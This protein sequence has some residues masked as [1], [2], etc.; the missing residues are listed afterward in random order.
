MNR[1]IVVAPPRCPPSLA[2]A[3]C[4][5]GALGIFDGRFAPEAEL[6]DGLAQI[7][8]YT[9]APYGLRLPLSIP[10]FDLT[11]LLQNVAR[12]PAALIVDVQ[13]QRVDQ[14]AV[15]GWRD[16]GFTVLAVVRSEAEAVV[17]QR[18]GVDG[19]LA[20]G[21]E[22][23][24]WVGQETTF[25]LLQRLLRHSHLP[26]W[27]WGGIGLHTAAAC[28]VAGAA[29]VVLDAQLALTR[30]STLPTAVKAAIRRMDGSETALLGAELNRPFRLY[31]RP[32][33]SLVEQL[34][35]RAFALLAEQKAEQWASEVEQKIGWGALTEAVWPLGQDAAFA[36]S[37]ADNY[38]TVGGV[39]A[40]L[41]ESIESHL[42][43]ARQLQPL[44]AQS[45]LAQAHR[46][47]Y[48]IVQ[49]PMTRVS[50]SVTFCSDVEAGGG[51]PFLAL[52]LLRAPQVEQLLAETQALMGERSWGVGILGFVPLDLR[53][54]QLA[55][56]LKYR[57]PFA[58]I[59]GGR[60]DQAQR[61]QEAGI[62]TYLHVPS[63]G[64]L[65]LFLKDGARHFIFEGRECG[66][67]VGPR[68]SFVLWESMIQ[69]LLEELPADASDCHLLFAGGIH[70]RLSAAMVAAMAAPLAARGVKVGVLMG[71]AYLFTEEAVSSG[72]IQLGFQEAA[73]HCDETVLL[74]SGPGHATRCAP[75]PF[76]D[77]FEQEKI[78]LYQAGHH[79]EQ[80]RQT[81]E[82]LN[83]GR[84]RIA[85]KGITRHPD[86]GATPDVPKYVTLSPEQQ[87]AD[88]MYM[89]GQVAAL[90]QATFTV[91][92]L[93]EEVSIEGSKLLQRLNR[94]E[95]VDDQPAKPSRVA[96]I[97]MSNFLPKAPDLESFW[98]NIR[99]GVYAI[100]E[101]PKTR[102]DWQL[103]FDE[104]PQARDKIYSRWGGFLEDVPFDPLAWGIP[105]ASLASI[106]PMHL[107]SLVAT[108]NALQDAGYAKRPFDRQHTS[109]ILGA[110]GGV[111]DLGAQYILRSGLPLLFGEAG[112]EL[113]TAAGNRLPQWTEDSFA[114]LLL[115]VAAGRIANRFDFGGVNYI[116]DAACASSL[117]ALYLAV[118]ELESGSSNVVIAGGV[119]TVQSPFGY[120]CFSK[121][122]ALSPDGRPRTFDAE[123]N[124]IAISEGVVMLV[125]KRLEDAE[126]DGDRIYA[127]IQGV[128]GSSDGRALS[129]TAPRAEGQRV[130]L[131][132]AYQ[133]AGFPITSVGLFEAH[134]TGTAVGDRTEALALGSFLAE[135][136]A[137]TAQHA[138]GSVKS[139]VGHTKASAGVAGVVKMALALYHQ[140]LPPTLG[141]TTPNPKANFKAG[142][143]YVNSETR[144]WI[145][146]ADHPRRAGVSAFG[147]G[148]T[149]FHAVLE[150]YTNPLPGQP[151]SLTTRWPA[152]LLLWR[153]ESPLKLREQLE[154]LRAALA[155]GATPALHDLS[156]TL[157]QQA[158][159][160]E[161]SYRLA[162]ITP[163]LDRLREQLD[164]ALALVANTSTRAKDP[165]GIFYSAES[166]VAEGKAALLFPGQGSQYPNMLRDLA[167]H[168]PEVRATIERHERT[169]QDRLAQ[170]LGR[171]IFPPPAF[172]DAE[173]E[174]QQAALTDTHVAQPALG[175][176]SSALFHLLQRFGI[177]AEATAGHSYGE[178]P[179]LYAAGV[180]DEETLA[181]LSE[182]RGRAITEA[183]QSDL[184]GMVAVRA[185]AQ[186]L[187]PFITEDSELW[188]ANL[189]SPQQT[190]VSGTGPALERFSAQLQADGIPHRL[191]NVA[192]AF[193]SPLVAPAQERLTHELDA[194][195]LHPPQ[196]P[197]Y[198]NVLAAPYGEDV[199]ENRA[200]LARHLLASVRFTEQI[201]TMYEDGVRTFIEVGPHTVVTGL[202]DHILGHQPHLAVATDHPQRNG[203]ESLLLALGQLAVEG[204]T[205]TLDPLFEGRRV[206][207]LPLHNLVKATAEAALPHS[208]WLVNGSGARRAG[209]DPVPLDGPLTWAQRPSNGKGDAVTPATPPP[210]R[211]QPAR[212][213]PANTNAPPADATA[214]PVVPNGAHH[215][216]QPPARREAATWHAHEDAG[217]VVSQFQQ[218]LQRFLSSQENVMSHYLHGAAAP[219][220]AAPTL[221][222]ADGEARQATTPSATPPAAPYSAGGE[223][224]VPAFRLVARPHP[225]TGN[226]RGLMAGGTVLI[227][228]DGSGLAQQLA[229][230][231]EA[232]GHP[233]AL[234]MPQTR[235]AEPGGRYIADLR[236]TEEVTQVV[237]LI[238]AEKGPITALVHLLPFS[239]PADW[240]D[241]DLESWQ[242]AC[243]HAVRALF[244]LCQAT[245][246][247][248]HHAAANGG[249]AVIAATA[250]GGQSG[251]NVVEDFSPA[252][253][254]VAGFLKSL[255]QEWPT[256]RLRA[257]DFARE[258]GV[259]QIA[260]HLTAELTHDDEEIEI[261]YRADE[262]WK[263]GVAAVEAAPADTPL[264]PPQSVVLLTGG[265]RG[266]TAEIAHQLA[267]RYR[268][269]LILAGRS[270]LPPEQEAAET[271]GLTEPAQIKAALIATVRHESGALDI[272]EVERRYGRLMAEREMRHTLAKLRAVGA[273]VSYQQADMTK[274]ADVAALFDRIYHEH[275]RLDGVV[276]GAGI[277]ADKLVTD[278]AVEDFDRV[279]RTK[280]ASSYLLAR[281]LR[282][283]KGLRF[284]ALFASVA[285]RFGNRGQSDYAAAN[286]TMAKT[287]QW[288]NRRWP[289]HV[290][291]LHWG[292]WQQGMADPVVQK[293]FAERGVQ[294]IAPLQGRI[295]FDEAMRNASA[296]AEL[297]LGNG[298]WAAANALPLMAGA[299]SLAQ[300][301]QRATWQQTVSLATMPY[302][303]DHRI[304]AVPVV[305]L[306]LATEWMAEAAQHLLPTLH[307][308]T[309]AHVEMLGGIRLEAD[310]LS[311]RIEAEAVP[312]EQQWR[313]AVKLADSATGRLFYR[314]DVWM[315]ESPLVAP[316]FQRPDFS[317]A[318]PY[319]MNAE[320]AYQT[321]IFH[322][323]C[324]Q[325]ISRLDGCS[326]A[327][328]AITLR[329]SASERCTDDVDELG[330]TIN[331]FLLD[332]A[333]QMTLFWDREQRNRSNLPARFD[334]FQPY[335]PLEQA[336]YVYFVRDARSTD[337]LVRGDYYF[338]DAAER[339]VAQLRGLEGVSSERLNAQMR[340][341]P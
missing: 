35:Q 274:E 11:S 17:A 255:A 181:H 67:H 314:G 316:P 215:D 275:G 290:V 13:D 128:A 101:I 285:G 173:R 256:V 213:E 185:D 284:V 235:H 300:E 297:V 87:S 142:P 338:V 151:R 28:H 313:V 341:N 144:P 147:F 72:A 340:P 261:G 114:G 58:I 249:A 324:F 204:A 250:L 5:A 278:K 155:A 229:P 264:L 292:P 60:P 9:D 191:L 321:R 161:A 115:N 107:L 218:M 24:G 184:G 234:L 4:R 162:L 203:I 216:T 296:E 187:E 86:Y 81:L 2:I 305:P 304:S 303:Y 56:I 186:R 301:R 104:N 90:H 27:A 102:W 287:A 83:I 71:T 253:G 277:I 207:R 167:L 257:V 208:M 6:V 192:C 64:L 251:L 333:P 95:P 227:T 318:K 302:L 42:E 190:I 16:E 74:E 262:R 62:T 225:L 282:P 311:V 160:S 118:R 111:G 36:A 294:I 34:H 66:G 77:L 135:Q 195:T 57:P 258:A 18:H 130:A 198:S 270:P 92:A 51:L 206:Q 211:P 231:W 241:S 193:H 15:Q 244:L 156:Y 91:A 48:P 150:E 259:E 169:L 172:T 116:V 325:R 98:H 154:Q 219:P 217:H 269:H 85:S 281:H 37:L 108:Q 230:Q 89:I 63:P 10:L 327:G 69:L 121:T 286:E 55:V 124:G 149:N 103:Y 263:V 59:A 332:V 143:L 75:S 109:V 276:H 68:S 43:S 53:Q 288:L 295:A 243:D 310:T 298:P 254:A 328:L 152:E 183:A 320:R 138:I 331:P 33:A 179:A 308:N 117:T 175:A 201:Q 129:M 163:S 312:V 205:L 30:E 31:T 268:P 232:Q 94:V 88:G 188:L 32:D 168:F 148:G 23:G 291:A 242:T 7:V 12:P 159:T 247:A 164:W 126:R 3:A 272:A 65:R 20:K 79:P 110:S 26:I 236:S 157:W 237:R 61:L 131:E 266:I 119:D 39:I 22:A 222:S 189:N 165:R 82:E 50:D 309:V 326:E 125:L 8:R 245:A 46:T 84:L 271:A 336:R 93:H 76:V 214:Q 238:E 106:D 123:G 182:V 41:R 73:I 202:V 339:L 140:T 133:K 158:S 335:A 221:P 299:H 248:L 209:S 283:E 78:K 329:N 137:G 273:T 240:L 146:S 280:T 212:E 197:L 239:L 99:E 228:D 174:A 29:G 177:R 134:G 317:A 70:D 307:L 319:S 153:A 246:P 180:I 226:A 19:L 40:A 49:G 200:V 306:A 127:V 171:Y 100:G 199:E 265:A 289:A 45:A 194:A 105:P 210:V 166:M 315:S 334:W 120:L 176:S 113:A 145:H 279:L 330:W 141:V 322:G 96:I 220:R 47:R 252:G 80:I 223:P 97:G 122:H 267:E 196:L 44:A 38:V 260:A 52:A 233:V 14:L 293:A 323:P 112:F 224:S 1:M 170:P 178:Y 136:G 337:Q 21:H 139:M 25:I 132:R 54:E